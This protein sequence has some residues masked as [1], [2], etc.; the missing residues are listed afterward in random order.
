MG[1]CKKKKKSLRKSLYAKTH[2]NRSNHNKMN[3]RE[4]KLQWKIKSVLACLKKKNK[5]RVLSAVCIWELLLEHS[6]RT[7]LVVHEVPAKT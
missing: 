3:F 7:M 4:Q 5:T 6:D 2:V 1:S